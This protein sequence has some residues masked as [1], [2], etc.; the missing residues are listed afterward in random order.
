MLF[1]IRVLYN[2]ILFLHFFTHLIEL[3]SVSYAKFNS[4]H[5]SIKYSLVE[6]KYEGTSNFLTNSLIVSVLPVSALI[7]ETV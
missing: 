5:I 1:F 4:A 2:S 7:T 6:K 3:Y